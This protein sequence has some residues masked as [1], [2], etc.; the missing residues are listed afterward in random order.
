[1]S[2]Y[3]GILQRQALLHSIRRKASIQAK[4]A[5][6]KV[7]GNA[8]NFTVAGRRLGLEKIRSKATTHPKKQEI[9]A[10]IR[11]CQAVNMSYGAIAE[12]LNQ[13]GFTTIR[14]K[15]FYRNT[16]RRLAMSL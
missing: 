11:K 9:Q 16:V 7:Y 10:I 15:R 13:N 8:Q 1:M 4:Q 2:I 3:A 12:A 5:H 6:G 14:G